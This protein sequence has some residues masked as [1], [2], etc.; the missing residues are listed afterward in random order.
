[1]L[2]KITNRCNLNCIHCLNGESSECDIDWNTLRTAIEFINKMDCKYLVITGGEPTEHKDLLNIMSYICN[3]LKKVK[4]FTITSNGVYFE[5]NPDFLKQLLSIDQRINVQIT[6]DIRYYPIQLNRKNKIYQMDR[7]V[8]CDKVEYIYPQGKALENNLEYKT[9]GSKCFN[10]IAILTQLTD[11]SIS[12][13][14]KTLERNSKY[15]TPQIDV[16][17]SLKPGESNL[18]KKFGTIYDS[19]EELVQNVLKFRC[20]QCDFINQKLP[21]PYRKLIHME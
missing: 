6:N 12:K 18:C 9:N 19:E 15:C 20:K 17:G 3:N 21:A 2:L 10:F 5:N 1:M 16:D 14:I 8:F 13:T 4:Y 7:V 11:K